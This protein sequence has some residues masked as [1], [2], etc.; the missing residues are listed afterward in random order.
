MVGLIALNCMTMTEFFSI[1]KD[2]S[3]ALAACVT[4]Y[5]AF[6]GL[7]KWKKELRGKANFEVA[8]A[9]IKSIYKLRDEITYCRS[10]FIRANEFPD[11]YK[12][13]LGKHSNQ[14]EGDAWAYMYG[15]RWEP[16][17]L[18]NEEFDAATL[19]AEAIWGSAIKE[20][21]EELSKCVRTL[22]AAINAAISDKYSGGED[23]RNRA[24]AE[25]MNANRSASILDKDNKLSMEIEK[26]IL[27]L[28]SE[29]RP[30]LSRE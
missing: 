19:E 11:N 26:S 10:P 17:V 7:E 28:E 3:L 18:S 6:T 4:A 25:S 30:H 8:R 14:E 23:F 13:T 16:V 21:T 27:A 12:G 9:L 20:K 22:N 15:K 1:L 5:V 2:L 29:I 24:F